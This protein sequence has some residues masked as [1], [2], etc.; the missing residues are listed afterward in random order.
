MITTIC[1]REFKLEV[2]S[3]L[4]TGLTE[5]KI[6]SPYVLNVDGGYLVGNTIYDVKRVFKENVDNYLK[7]G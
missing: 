1:Y 2:I 4:K 5:G 7:D 3:N 6:I